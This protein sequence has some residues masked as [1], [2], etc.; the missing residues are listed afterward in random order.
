MN[1]QFISR[2]LTGLAILLVG[3]G[4]LL[5]A[6]DVLPFWDYFGTWWPLAVVLLSAIIVIN[7]RRQYIVSLALFVIGLFALLNNLDIINVSFWS[8]LWPVVIIAVGL[9]ILINRGTVPKTVKTQDSDIASAI[10]GGS[11]IINKSHDYQGGKLTALFGGISLDL[12]DA[13]IK[14]EATIEIFAVCGGAEI[15]V[16]RE[17]RVLNQTFPILGGVESKNHSEKADDKA[18][19]L[20]ITGTVALG[21]VE[22]HS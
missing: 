1:G 15:K 5:H 8:I 20:I 9:S 4:A 11:E 22:I 18:P 2:T 16:P 7:D 17:W 6:I 13:V 12:R 10:F 19:V 21:G 14:K 3:I